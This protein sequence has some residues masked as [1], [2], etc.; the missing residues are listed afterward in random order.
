MNKNADDA[1]FQAYK[2]SNSIN[3]ILIVNFSGPRIT[4]Y[5]VQ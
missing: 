3:S 5:L 4:E 1:T 2:I